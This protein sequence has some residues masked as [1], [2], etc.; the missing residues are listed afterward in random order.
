MGMVSRRWHSRHLVGPQA[1]GLVAQ[2][3]RQPVGPAG[4]VQRL[5]RWVQHGLA[6]QLAVLEVAVA[7]DA[8]IVQ[9]GDVMDARGVQGGPSKGGAG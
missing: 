3:Q 6:R 9:P 2:H 4:L 8:G 1:L 5:G 7:G